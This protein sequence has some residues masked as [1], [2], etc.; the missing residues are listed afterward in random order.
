ML[1]QLIYP[2]C[3]LLFFVLSPDSRPE[4]RSG[5]VS[6]V[7]VVNGARIRGGKG[8]GG[9]TAPNSEDSGHVEHVIDLLLV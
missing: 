6:A 2:F 4:C 7:P 3:C 8:G 9:G 1:Q 5:F